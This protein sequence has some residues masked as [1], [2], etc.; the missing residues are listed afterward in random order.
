M[1]T[2]PVRHMS[3]LTGLVGCLVLLAGIAAAA[4]LQLVVTSPKN[5]YLPDEPLFV[6]VTLNNVGIAELAALRLLDPGD[7]VVSF[8]I[9][10]P[11][12]ELHNYCPWV[13]S[14]WTLLLTVLLR[15][16]SIWIPARS[17]ALRLT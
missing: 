5:Q 1:M 7:G 8:E 4:D 16:Q 12:E 2:S 9:S 6:T 15:R 11:G 17:T 13:R 3:T 14:E 10:A